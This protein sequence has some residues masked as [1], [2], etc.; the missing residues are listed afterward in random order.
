MWGK[1]GSNAGEFADASGLA[2]DREGRIYVAD[3]ANKRVQV[4]D[5]NFT[6]IFSYWYNNKWQGEVFS[7]TDVA[8][9]RNFQVFT[10]EFSHHLIQ[11]FKLV[12]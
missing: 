6:H 7:P 2:I 3:S 11:K 4:F 1:Q 10:A 12:F 5:S 9:D 8:V